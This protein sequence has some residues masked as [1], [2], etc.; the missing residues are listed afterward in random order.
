MHD[1]HL[2]EF[3][4]TPLPQIPQGNFP[5]FSF[6]PDISQ[7]LITFVLLKF[8][9]SPFSS[10]S[11]AHP[12]FSWPKLLGPTSRLAQPG[13]LKQIGL[14]QHSALVQCSFIESYTTMAA[15]ANFS[16]QGIASANIKLTS[17][18]WSSGLRPR[19][20]GV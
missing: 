7:Y 17:A 16:N 14:D 12:A 9:L 15:L 6:I 20:G 8:I 1:V 5:N 18:R 10:T 2:I 13:K 19:G 11:A 4:P 3:A